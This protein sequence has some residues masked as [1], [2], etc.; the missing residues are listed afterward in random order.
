MGDTEL[1]FAGCGIPESSM[2]KT[3]ALVRGLGLP[4]QPQQPESN[5]NCH[6]EE[7]ARIVPDAER[8]RAI[9]PASTKF[10]IFGHR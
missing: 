3:P 1:N 8:V 5:L 2:G 10:V 9:F 6:R 7:G 4:S